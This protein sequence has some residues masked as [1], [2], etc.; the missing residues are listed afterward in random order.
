[1]QPKKKKIVSSEFPVPSSTN[2]SREVSDASPF[3]ISHQ[4]SSH[5]SELSCW[6]NLS[7]RVALQGSAIAGGKA[8]CHTAYQLVGNTGHRTSLTYLQCKCKL[9]PFGRYPCSSIVICLVRTQD[10]QVVCKVG[11]KVMYKNILVGSQ[12]I[13]LIFKHS[14]AIQI[15]IAY[16]IV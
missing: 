13:I 16:N 10:I 8:G 1:M 14:Q 3:R 2:L 9:S 15:H 11:K 5:Q 6:D 7:S 12:S 4:A